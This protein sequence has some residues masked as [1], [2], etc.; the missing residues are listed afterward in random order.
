MRTKT[1]GTQSISEESGR[2]G[3]AGGG[4]AACADGEGQLQNG[5]VQDKKA[6]RRSLGF[7]QSTG[8]CRQHL[9]RQSDLHF[10]AMTP[11]PSIHQSFIHSFIH[12]TTGSLNGY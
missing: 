10:G 9:A 2:Q 11:L 12:L 7:I 8:E 3:S 4:E 5:R 6:S 1:R